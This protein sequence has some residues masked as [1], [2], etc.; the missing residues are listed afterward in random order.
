MAFAFQQPKKK[1]LSS[2]VDDF[3]GLGIQELEWLMSN[4]P[5][6]F[7]QLGNAFSWLDPASNQAKLDL[8]RNSQL[9]TA[10]MAGRNALNTARWGGLG[11]GVQEAFLGNANQNAMNNVAQ[12]K[13]MLDSP[14]YTL[15]SLQARQGL[16]NPF[17]TNQF[18]D[19]SGKR[20]GNTMAQQQAKPKKNNFLGGLLNT[21]LQLAGGGMFGNPASWFGGGASAA[22]KWASNPSSWTGFGTL[23][24]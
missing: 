13:F 2:A 3:K 16:M 20:Y 23:F 12:Y 19:L 18:Y 8:F 9:Q 17:F 22:S 4:A 5:S 7:S 11:S 15:Q 24:G 6:Y 21:G 1:T 10:S 14:E